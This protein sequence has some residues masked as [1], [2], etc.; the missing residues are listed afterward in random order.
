MNA[1]DL[2]SENAELRRQLNEALAQQ[3]AAA[4]IL[5]VI[6]SSGDLAP[7][8][9]AIVEKA[10][11]LCNA[12]FGGLMIRDGEVY[13]T[14]ALISISPEHEAFVRAR[15]FVSSQ[16]GS[17]VERTAFERRIVHI[18]NIAAEPGYPGSVFIRNGTVLGVPLLRGG[19]PIGV[20]PLARQRVEPFTDRQIALL[21]NFAA[22]AVIAMENARLITETREAL[23][24]QTASAE[25]LGVISSSP[26]YLKP[27]F[28]AIVTNAV[29][30]C[31]GSAGM[32]ALREG[33]GFRGA[34]ADGFGAQFADM[35]SGLY[36]PVPGTTLD[37]IEQEPRTVQMPDLLAVP[38][39][40]AIRTLVPEY[41]KVRTHLA[42]P[43]LKE[44]ELLGSILIYRDEVRPFDDKQVELVENFA[45]QA[46]I[47]IENARLIAE[48]REALEQQTATAEVLGVINASPGDLPPVFDAILEKAH[49]LCGAD[50]GALLT[51]DGERFR[52]AAGSGASARFAEMMRDGICPSPHNG[53][54]RL[55]RGERFVH[56]HDMI[57][58]A[59]QLD[60][61]VPRALAETGEMRTQL[62]VPLRN[63]DKVLGVITA[64]RKEVRPFT[65]KQ[66]ALLQN[67]AAQA[68]IAMENARLITETRE[69]L[70][71][72]TATAEI[73]GVINSSPGDLAPVFD[74][75][76]QKAT[77]LCEPAF[78][79]LLTWEGDRFRRVAWHGIPPELIEATRQPM[80]APPPG[81][82]GKRIADGEN[83][84]AIADLAE[85]AEAGRGPAIQT[86]MRLGGRSYVAV[87]LR[88]EDELLGMLAIY[89][90]EVRPFSEKE[91][92]LLQN[93]A[94]Q[95]VI[96][97][98]NARLMSETREALEQQTATAEVLGVINSSPGNL[99]P[100]FDA[101]LE[102]ATQLCEAANGTLWTYDGQCFRGAAVCGDP[103]YAAWLRQQAPTRPVDMVPD[104]LLRG[105]RDWQF[106][107]TADSS[108]EDDYRTKPF[109]REMV[110]ASRCKT[111][112]T[113]ALRKDEQLRGIIIVYRHEVRL[114]TDKQIALLQNFAA[115]AVIAMENARLIT[116]TRE[117]LEQQTATAEILG[118]I[119]SSPGDL[120]P[121]FDTMLEKAI[122]LCEAASGFLWEYDGE[123][124]RANAM[125]GV[126]PELATMLQQQNR[127]HPETGIGRILRG[128]PFVHITDIA[129]GAA[130]QEH[131]GIHR[132]SV[133]LGGIRTILVVPM[134]RHGELVG[135]LTIFRKEVRNFSEKE[136]ALLQN[137]AAQAVIAM[138]NAR[139]ITE[140]R[141]ALEQQ[142]A[143]AEVLG[144]INSYPGDLAPVFDAILE[145]A[146]RLC[147]ITFGGLWTFDGERFHPGS[148]RG[149]PPAL[150]D[151]VRAPVRPGPETALGRVARGEAVVQIDDLAAEPR[152]D[153]T[154]KITVE[155]G[156]ARTFLA[157]P[158]RKEGNIL[159][160]I[161]AY[162]QEVRPFSD[163]QI[164]LLRSFAAQAVI[165]ME[166]ARLLG[167]LRQRTEE[168]AE[169]NRG[170]ETRVAEQV[171]ELG[172]V[173]RLKR[174]LAPQLAELIVSQG[175]EKIFCFVKETA[176]DRVGHSYPFNRAL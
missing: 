172:R 63:D 131:E 49:T 160:A 92:A 135:G 147:D 110:N 121:V 30:I 85:E 171:E 68:V 142:T 22:Q 158:L 98:E 153:P 50:Y 80:A 34:A 37:L 111:A 25:V 87:A 156:G 52:P 66:I 109:Y 161:A 170:L 62:M 38:A 149:V 133:D 141:E 155:L 130:Y 115:Q 146:M 159:G 118:V 78:G 26:G 89:R 44:N 75:I 9:E 7:V 140:T 64:N 113:V 19:E 128:E 31:G 106:V 40:D 14:A 100:V 33:N 4:E 96:A 174:F 58:H 150:A 124:F 152:D 81:A 125:K 12:D 127:P 137:F 107:Q 73:L 95:A 54:G 65:D 5:Q 59:Q 166:N 94:A 139:L 76:L 99:A 120:T 114:F 70:E 143:T 88:K 90:K 77:E 173:G 84:V 55:M 28:E 138:E 176:Q 86:M 57:E 72:Q 13:R 79:S 6:N 91:S 24:R 67:F 10:T 129:A 134:R 20:M 45:K 123:F 165:A 101:M 43:M 122:R 145:K 162:R 112:L 105:Q 132:A 97:M 3:G 60:D 167:E 32:L 11:R 136:I 2:A 39:Y 15:T 103:Q 61:P 108:A 51:Y 47:A 119:N 164:A 74:T 116:E 16:H 144:V 29:R 117:A 169:L 163:K 36:R 102:Q 48:T 53:F 35:L 8:F 69:A 126:V 168:V 175:D 56:I 46:V 21:Q 157:V 93:F 82:P 18:P 27:V 148:F 41:A 83:V 104:R 154:R 71:Q 23:E 151:S 42:V 17:I 1:S